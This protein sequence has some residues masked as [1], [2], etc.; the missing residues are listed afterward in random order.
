MS[1]ILV[2]CFDNFRLLFLGSAST[3]ETP[4]EAIEA[5]QADEGNYYDL[6]GRKVSKPARGVYIHNGKKLITK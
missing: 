1:T 5:D 2:T 4:V 3:E 6:A